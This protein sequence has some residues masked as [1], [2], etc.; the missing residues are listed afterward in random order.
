MMMKAENFGKLKFLII[1]KIEEARNLEDLQGRLDVIQRTI[2]EMKR[3]KERALYPVKTIEK[4]K[5][6]KS[7]KK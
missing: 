7:E 3:P 5:M 4:K 1:K 6:I 2:Q